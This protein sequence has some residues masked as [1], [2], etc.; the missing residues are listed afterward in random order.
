VL[1]NVASARV[2]NYEMMPSAMMVVTAGV[3]ATARQR[4]IKRAAVSGPGGGRAVNW[5]VCLAKSNLSRD[6]RRG[7]IFINCR[8][9]FGNQDH[10]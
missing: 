8:L 4:R 3:L 9:T 2:V 7:R 10:G 1:A 5:P 6:H